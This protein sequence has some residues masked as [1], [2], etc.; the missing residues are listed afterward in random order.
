MPEKTASGP[1][2][3]IAIC[4]VIVDQLYHE[5]I[6]KK[7]MDTGNTETESPYVAEI[8]VHS[9]HPEKIEST[10]LR[11]RLIDKL[12]FPDWNSPEVVRA[13][14][15]LL[16]FSLNRSPEIVFER[17]IFCTESCIPVRSLAECGISLFSGEK[18][19]VPAYNVPESSWEDAHCFKAVN[20][21]VIPPKVR[22]FFFFFIQVCL[23]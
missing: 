2:K 15:Q 16:N 21:D 20:R 18:S 6:W 17:F 14:L 13:M 4:I 9:K 19:W 22:I 10:W 1:K 5:E 11:E 8:F 3:Y 23:V 7:W 12:F